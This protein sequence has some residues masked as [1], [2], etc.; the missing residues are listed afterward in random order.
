MEPEVQIAPSILAADFSNLGH[1]VRAMAAAG[2]DSIHIDVMDGHFVPN[3]TIGPAAVKALRSHTERPF[4]VHLM[5]DPVMPYVADF[6]RAGADSITVHVE[7]GSQL[8]PTLDLI[9]SEGKKTGLAISPGTPLSAVTPFLWSVDLLLVM[10]VKPG[11]G[12]QKFM[13]EE[14]RKVQ[15]LR[16]LIDENGGKV[17]VQVD[18]GVNFE[19]A[20]EAVAAGANILVA[21]TAAFADGADSYRTNL[22]RLRGSATC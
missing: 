1:E 8:N 4:D 13:R 9:K 11:F 17:D 22:A 12:G 15:E 14:L 6:A 2:A 19:T 7:I 10:T 21:G 20:P 3:L 18:G 5:I 16:R